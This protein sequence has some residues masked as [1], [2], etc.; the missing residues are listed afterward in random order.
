M[1]KEFG[2]YLAS[3]RKDAGY[4]SMSELARDSGTTTASISRIEKGKQNPSPELLKKLAPYLK[5]SHDILMSRAGF[6]IKELNQREKA[7][8]QMVADLEN[9]P[10]LL[11]FYQVLR[12]EE[13]LRKILRQTAGLPS[14][15]KKQVI[16]L[17]K[18]VEERE[19]GR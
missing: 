3:L 8:A 7:D 9:D 5:V 2:I 10:E 12:E 15:A 4:S 14:E 18:V 19:K 6:T 16:G 17:I 1:T 13:D 11:Y